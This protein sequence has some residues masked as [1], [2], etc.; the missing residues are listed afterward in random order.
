MPDTT[1]QLTVTLISKKLSFG[2]PRSYSDTN[3]EASILERQR[4]KVKASKEKGQI[5]TKDGKN[6]GWKKKTFHQ[7]KPMLKD[8]EVISLMC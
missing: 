7:Q 6:T 2:K 8:N 1:E 3:L 5:T 4:E